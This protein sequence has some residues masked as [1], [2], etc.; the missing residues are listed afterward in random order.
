MSG[1]VIRSWHYG[2]AYIV[3]QRH[4]SEAYAFLRNI[5]VFDYEA[6]LRIFSIL[7]SKPK[8][9]FPF[10]CYLLIKYMAFIMGY[11]SAKLFS[12]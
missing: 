5:S 12:R 1:V 7:A 3:L 10:S 9:V 6:I 4:S 2:G 11:V 8:A